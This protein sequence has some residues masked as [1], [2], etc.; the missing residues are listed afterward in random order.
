MGDNGQRGLFCRQRKGRADKWEG[1][2]QLKER[3]DSGNDS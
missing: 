2:G 3:E 1:W